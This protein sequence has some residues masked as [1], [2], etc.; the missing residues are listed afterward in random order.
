MRFGSDSV[1]AAMEVST[2][3]KQ[4]TTQFLF[5]VM[6]LIKPSCPP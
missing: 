5:K 2:K 3:S 4:I 1:S 6:I